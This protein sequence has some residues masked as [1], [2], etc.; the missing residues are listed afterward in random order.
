MTPRSWIVLLAGF[1]LIFCILA[2]FGNERIHRWTPFPAGY[3]AAWATVC[4]A[5]RH[6]R[7]LILH[8][9]SVHYFA[10]DKGATSN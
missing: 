6:V 3:I 9:G 5:F 7:Y 8:I 4:Y 1:G 2:F 10:P